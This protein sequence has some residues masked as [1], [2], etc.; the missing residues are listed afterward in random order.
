MP[1]ASAGKTRL[2]N[3]ASA[4]SASLPAPVYQA[5][6]IWAREH[7]GFF[8]WVFGEGGYACAQWPPVIAWLFPAF[9]ERE[10]LGPSSFGAM[11]AKKSCGGAE[12]R[13]LVTSRCSVRI[14]TQ[15]GHSKL[16]LGRVPVSYLKGGERGRN[17]TFNL[18]IK[19][20]LLCQLSY[21]PEVGLLA[22]SLMRLHCTVRSRTRPKQ[23]ALKSTLYA[24]RALKVERWIGLSITEVAEP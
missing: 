8:I 21:A 13:L 19:S 24:A 18:L 11:I 10:H 15:N 3:S 22:E 12:C 5:R 1:V 16:V 9:F 20:Q 6:L 23:A 4:E 7:A 2:A 17:R 14:R